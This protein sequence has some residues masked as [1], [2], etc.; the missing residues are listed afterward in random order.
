MSHTWAIRLAAEHAVQLGSLRRTPGLEVCTSDEAVWVRGRQ[1]ED[2]LE[3]ILRTLP[4]QRF[5]V[6]DDGQLLPAG[7]RVPDGQLP[8]AAWLP[9]ADWLQIELPPAG[10]P[11]TSFRAVRLQMVRAHIPAEINVV[12]TDLNAW[13]VYGVRAPQLR[14]DRW[15]FAVSKS[16][17]VVVRGAP[18]PALPGRRYVEQN[19]IAAEAGWTWTPAVS[20]D[21]LRQRFQLAAGDLVLL[22]ADGSLER[23]PAQ[24]FVRASRSA[25]R[26]SPEEQAHV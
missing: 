5:T 11:E 16:H 14:L 7:R 23:I 21:V 3:R 19:G 8:Q 22:R 18:I 25:I 1:I 10:I 9:L 12:H 2:Q 13:Q 4:A 20:V 17:Q 6:L 26:S 15:A 24:A